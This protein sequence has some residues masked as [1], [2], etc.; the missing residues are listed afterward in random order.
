[1][2]TIAASLAIS[3]GG[4]Q[5]AGG[6]F[7]PATPGTLTVATSLPALGFWD[8]DDV[9]DLTG[10]FEWGIAEALGERFDVEV[11]YLDVPFEQLAAGDLGE[12]DL[13]LAQISITD[14]RLDQMDLSEPYY[15]THAG[16]LAGTDVEL[17]DLADAKELRWVVEESTTEQDFLE[18]VIR[19]DDEPIVSADRVGTLAALRD[20]RAR[21]RA[22][23]PAHR[24][25][26]GQPEP[27]PRRAGAVR[28]RGAVRRGA[29]EG[30]GQHRGGE[31]RHP[32]L[33]H[34]RHARRSHRHVLDASARRRPRRRPPDHHAFG[35]LMDLFDL[36]SPDEVTLSFFAV[37]VVIA[38]GPWLAERLRLPGLIGL[39][40]GGFVIGPYA[41]GIVKESDTFVSSLGNLGLL[42]LMYLAGLDLDLDILRRSK[43]VAITF[44]IL[45]FAF[46]MLFGYLAAEALGY[47]TAAA[48][49]LGSI[50]ASHTLLT[51]P[52]LRRYGLSNQRAVATTVGATVI[53]DTMALVVLAAVSG[54][55]TGSAGGVELFVQITLGLLVLAAFSFLALPRLVQWLLPSLGQPATVR[56]ILAFA[57]L[58]SAVLVSEAFG[59]DGIVGAF[60]AGLALNPLI[61]KAGP[62]FEHI[63]FYGSALFIPLFLVSVG[64]IIEPSVM[65]EP[66]TIGTAAVFALACVGGKAIAATLCKP[67]FGYSWD[68]VG[69]TFSLSVNQAAATLAAT[70]VGYEIGLFGTTVVNA[71]LIV[72]VVTVV[73]GGIAAE[74]YGRRLPA[75]PLDTSRLGRTVMVVVDTARDSVVETEVASMGGE[76]GFGS[77]RPPRRAAR[78]RR[79]RRRSADRGAEQ[80]AGGA[81]AR[82]RGRRA[83]GSVGA[84]RGRQRR[85]GTE[86]DDRVRARRPA[87][88]RGRRVRRGGGPPGAADACADRVRRPQRTAPSLP[89]RARA[90]RT[91]DRGPPGLQVAFDLAARFAKAGRPI[92]VYS[93]TPIPADRLTALGDPEVVFGQDRAAFVRAREIDGEAVIVPA[94]AGTSVFS[95]DVSDLTTL[96]GAGLLIAVGSTAEAIHV[97]TMGRNLAAGRSQSA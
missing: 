3:C 68:E 11:T 23:R 19:P 90:P 91:C 77:S 85:S 74:R 92:T 78:R 29:A 1:M 34:G 42:Y 72:I 87:G 40:F 12:A 53:T 82:H 6:S 14:G 69:A 2:V 36:H 28:H 60:F 95:D 96:G 94:P 47:E 26:G 58:L 10:G 64:L 27:G 43:R 70:F 50:W 73:L 25:G 59:I 22:A 39:L 97:V 5:D 55:S 30:L 65:V 71:V 18:D 16:A 66:A 15:L 93:P 24:D 38:V 49:L 57:A 4:D 46:P 88:V 35:G 41:L 62:L 9:D 79:R 17:R 83:S 7:E 37:L 67:I 21:G 20:G 89:A 56:Y 61:P 52:T 13:A 44:A 76:G 31:H 48:I 8:G 75:P 51:Y 81:W 80:L 33:R 54:Y 84:G 45:T 32:R 63:E 86:S